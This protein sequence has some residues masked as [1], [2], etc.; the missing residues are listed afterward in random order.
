[1]INNFNLV[2]NTA[3]Y[4]FQ[5]DLKWSKHVEATLKKIRP[6]LSMLRKIRKNLDLEQ[7]LKVA[8]ACIMPAQYG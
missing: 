2:L 6:K 4:S 3:H 8:T 1:M 5:S 7:F